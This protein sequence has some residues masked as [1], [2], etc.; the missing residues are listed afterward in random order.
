MA[1]ITFFMFLFRLEVGY[2]NDIHNR[3][4]SILKKDWNLGAWND[5]RETETY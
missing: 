2:V 3:F 5:L 4:V 1:K